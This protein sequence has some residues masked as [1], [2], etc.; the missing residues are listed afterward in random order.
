MCDGQVTQAEDAVLPV[1][2]ATVNLLVLT[3]MLPA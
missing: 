1:L 3:V 2:A